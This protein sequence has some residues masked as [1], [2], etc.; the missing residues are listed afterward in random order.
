MRAVVIGAGIA[1]LAAAFRLQQL[2]HSVTVL[3][4]GPGVGGRALLLNRPSTDEWIDA[5]T[6]YFHSNYKHILGL[7]DDLGMSGQTKTI[8]GATRFHVEGGRQSF[9]VTPQKPWIKAGGIAGNW[10]A[11]L[12]ALRLLLVDRGSTFAVL[13]SSESVLDRQPGL[14]STKHAF[15]RDYIVRMLS[16]VGGL[17]EPAFA[18]VSALQIRRLMRIILTTEYIG[19]KGGTASLH[20]ALAE[21]LDVRLNSPVT[22]LLRYGQ[23]VFGVTLADRTAIEADHVIVAAQPP[24]AHALVPE[25]WA[26]IRHYLRGI[27]TSKAILVHLFLDRSV[28]AGVW[29][30]FMPLDHDG[31]VQFFVDTQQK[32]MERAVSGCATMQAWI[33]SPKS[34]ALI[35]QGDA[36]IV[37]A[38]IADLERIMPGAGA[39]VTGHQVTRHRH[40][41]PQSSV[42]HEAATRRFLAEV[43]ALEGIGFCG[44]YLSGG[45]AEC[46]AWSA[47]REVE[48]ITAMQSRPS[49]R[50]VPTSASP[51]RLT[52]EAA[53]QNA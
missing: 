19:L 31:P 29:T 47:Q 27:A 8:G 6:Q 11:L 38:T 9:L 4:A 43:D 26:E 40:A 12:Y 15:V 33:L 46:A 16:L 28:E 45:Y 25:E 35:E 2:G 41:V 5:G 17:A 20:A 30:H 42:G 3:E 21:R 36:A 10:R 13:T 18:N 32:S 1:G 7:I 22:S 44:D 49:T 37:A 23:K 48:R 24:H 39:W 50:D 52:P 53:P 51:A 14:A 34:D